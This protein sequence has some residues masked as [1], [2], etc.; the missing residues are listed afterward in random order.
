MWHA[1]YMQ[2][3]GITI[4]Q[5]WALCTSTTSGGWVCPGK[6]RSFSW[7]THTEASHDSV[8][9]SRVRSVFFLTS[10]DGTTVP[11][12]SSNVGQSSM[13][14]LFVC[15]SRWAVEG[16]RAVEACLPVQLPSHPGRVV[17][18]VTSMFLVWKTQTWILKKKLLSW[19]TKQKWEKQDVLAASAQWHHNSLTELHYHAIVWEHLVGCTVSTCFALL[20]HWNSNPSFLEDF[21]GILSGFVHGFGGN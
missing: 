6:K 5:I 12:T 18:C 10:P 13:S 8:C 9:D 19:V 20:P 2:R 3:A 4:F 17:R 11:I 7:Y 15:F 14:W 21:K 1:D 16:R